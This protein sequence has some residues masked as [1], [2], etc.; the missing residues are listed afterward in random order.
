MIME[1]VKMFLLSVLP[2][3]DF[4]QMKKRNKTV[5]TSL[6]NNHAAGLL[7]T[8][9]VNIFSER[10]QPSTVEDTRAVC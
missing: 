6:G 9:D 4:W 5:D 2:G 8:N 1:R 7:F 10:L 3:C